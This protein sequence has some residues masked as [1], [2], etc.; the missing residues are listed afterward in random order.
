[1]NKQTTI[2]TALPN[3]MGTAGGAHLKISV[4]VSP[5]L[6]STDAAWLSLADPAYADFLHWPETVKSMQFTVKFQ[7]R[8][9]LTISPVIKPL[10]DSLWT[11]LFKPATPVEPYKIPDVGKLQINSFPVR[12]VAMRLKEAYQAVA[13]NSP[14]VL[15]RADLKTPTLQPA[16]RLFQNM[17]PSAQQRTAINRGL[18]S[19]L[20][21]SQV[22]ALRVPAYRSPT[23]VATHTEMKFVPMAAEAP[24]VAGVSQ[25]QADFVQF[26][27][28]HASLVGPYKPLPAVATLIES[29]DFHQI[30][31]NLQQ[32]PMVMRK[33]GLVLELQV[34]LDPALVGAQWVRVSPV[35][36]P[37][38]TKPTV[39]PRTNITLDSERFVAKPK[40]ADSDIADGML[41]L[42]D[43]D[44]F[45]IGQVDV[46]G[47]AL[48]LAQ[49]AQQITVKP[50]FM[51]VAPV[52]V[53]T[54]GAPA[55]TAPAAP[56]SEKDEAA[57]LPTLR[58]AGI[59]VARVDRAPQVALAL[60]RTALFNQAVLDNKPEEI[61]LYAEDLVRGYRIDVWDETADKWFS[62]CQ[63]V[64]RYKFAALSQT[65]AMQDEG[66]VSNAAVESATK[67]NEVY[68]HETMF[69]WEGWSL[70]APRPGGA[71]EPH[72]GAQPVTDRFGL[73]VTF[74]AKP[75][76][77]PRL[78]FGREYRLRAR[79]VDLAGN[80]L[81]LDEA[82]DS[83]A[84]PPHTYFRAE[85]VLPPIVIP[86][87]PL[88]DKTPGESAE[89]LA[90][91]SRNDRPAKDD[92]VINK[93]SQR[94][95]LPPRT[96][97]LMAETHG[98]FD[99]P[100]SMKGDA[101]TYQMIVNKDVK[102]RR[103]YNLDQVILP[104]L[105]DPLAYGV[106]VRLRMLP[107]SG[108]PPPIAAPP[109]APAPP[110][111]AA[112]RGQSNLRVGGFGAGIVKLAARPNLLFIE[113]QDQILKIPFGEDWPDLKPVR[114]VLYEPKDPATKMTYV[115]AKRVLQVPLSKGEAAE[116][117]ISCYLKPTALP[118]MQLWRWTVEGVAAPTVRKANLAPAQALELHRKLHQPAAVPQ[119]SAQVKLPARLVKDL[120]TLAVQARDGRNWLTTPFRR[121]NLVHATQQPLG[122]PH[123]RSLGASRSIGQTFA[124]LHDDVAVSGKTT[125]KLEIL[126]KWQ[127]RID[128]LGKPKWETLDGQARVGEIAVDRDDAALALG[129]LP[130]EFHD[131][132][133][134]HVKYQAVATT[135]YADYFLMRG[136]QDPP[137]PNLVFTRTSFP[138]E[139][140]IDVLSSA[141]PLAPKV[142][143]VI[144]AFGWDSDDTPMKITSTRT[145]GWLRVYLERPWY[146][147]G[148]GELL[149]V[150][151]GPPPPTGI[152]IAAR[153][154]TAAMQEKLKPC[155]THW[156]QDPL[157]V[158]PPMR[159]WPVA[160][161]FKG[162]AATET[163]LS[164]EEVPGAKVSV[165]G[166][167]V[168][169]DQKRQ[170]WYADIQVDCGEAYYPFIRLALVRY[171][172][173]SISGAQGDVK[174]SRV[175]L[176][177]MAQLAPDR[178]AT[179]TFNAGDPKRVAI[180]VTGPTYQR[181]AASR[182]SSEM[183]VTLEERTG[184]LLDAS[185]WRPVPDVELT[186]N[187]SLI[188][189]V[190]FAWAG[191]LVLPASRKTKNYRLV[192][193]EYETFLADAPPPTGLPLLAALPTTVPAKR[194]VYANVM[195]V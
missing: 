60:Q 171:Q 117:W 75:L 16:R 71:V 125:N 9:A 28:F 130:H 25:A 136:R 5:R 4:L 150:V 74:S 181:S 33:L 116:L 11:A 96:S 13:I 59:W 14:V 105:P 168:A 151:L 86:R 95:L 186:L 43:T 93:V 111:A 78:R 84:T 107:S 56:A 106:L 7:G 85:P 149:G 50:I 165:V 18:A 138:S 38:A 114:L 139:G 141:R 21:G 97:Q 124:A 177:D 58:S 65:L 108:K 53:G 94:H 47:A 37:A 193:K 1:M 169:Y 191:N 15:P 32:Y 157:W 82:D 127:E 166:Y 36:T 87:T 119:W 34:P 126:A 170:L 24:L 64:G 140:E 77:L 144:P 192:L 173:K 184:P 88:D 155:V 40:N 55:P 76:S 160:A 80:G 132:K 113:P 118:K 39:A 194:V 135:R 17:A 66:W 147:S 91:R 109:P 152:R 189:T 195:E 62:V 185:S 120:D 112:T 128:P 90:I 98:E 123:F 110:S 8:P 27:D 122:R 175:Q 79:V 20:Q 145:G 158:A 156:G 49:V 10:D 164:L 134:R 3:G 146:S 133:Y 103:F 101:A 180:R 121:L 167:D 42:N 31:A 81:A 115:K 131:T 12:N 72:S 161:D 29:I 188:R 73:D 148:D 153:P 172:P 57:P 30:V 68:V 154:A 67:P 69:R 61:S 6:E 51:M 26:Q 104:Y 48:K 23:S 63:R 178:K 163:G 129:G 162:A 137:P 89:V 92:D 45:E 174:L 182:G 46:D 35:G 52:R 183:V 143:Y 22:R 44:K 159:A 99:G 41:P 19:K 54:G 2:W 83:A 187:H 179:L 176:A 100:Q 142:L 70:V 102:P 190:G